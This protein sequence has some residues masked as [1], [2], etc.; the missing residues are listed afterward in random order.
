MSDDN[1]APM[2]SG[3]SPEVLTPE[4]LA[5]L[6]AAAGP[7]T[8][9]V[10]ELIDAVIR[11]EVEVEE[12]ESVRKEIDQLTERLRA[13]QLPGSFGVRL[14]DGRARA[15]GN[16]VVGLRNAMAPPLVVV[17]EPD[18]RVWCEVV[19]GAR[20]EGPPG[21][22]HGGV[23]SLLLD[24]IIGEASAAAGAPGMTGTLKLRYRSPTPLGPL[25]LEAQAVRSEGVKTIVRGAISVGDGEERRV[26]VEAEAIM[27]MPRWAREQIKATGTQTGFG[28][29]A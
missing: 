21:L 23:S 12:L 4:E 17:H 3:Y 16:P 27:I 6:A 13:R 11:S 26:C 25:R 20:F 1:Y 10:R 29:E 5:R 18:G 19:L 7:L 8:D 2:K 22:V 24:Q 15:W 14:S 28:G 9:S